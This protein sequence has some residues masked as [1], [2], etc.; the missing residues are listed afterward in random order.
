MPETVSWAACSQIGGRLRGAGP[1]REDD[2]PVARRRLHGRH[3]GDLVRVGEGHAL[4]EGRDVD[5]HLV[6]ALRRHRDHPGA[7]CAAGG[8]ALEALADDG[9]RHAADGGLG[10]LDPVLQPAADLLA[11][12]RGG[13]GQGEQCDECDEDG[14][15]G[16]H[17]ASL[18][19]RRSSREPS[20]PPGT[21]RESSADV[22]QRGQ[23]IHVLDTG[24]AVSGNHRVTSCYVP[25]TGRMRQVSRPVHSGP[26]LLI[27]DPYL[28]ARHG[29]PEGERL[30]H[31]G[32]GALA[33]APVVGAGDVEPD[34]HEALAGVQGRPDGAGR[35][36]QD[37]IG[38]AVQ[39]AVGLGV[40]RHRHREHDPLGGGLDELDAHRLAEGTHRDAVG[41]G[42]G[43]CH[44]RRI[45]SRRAG[46]ETA[47]A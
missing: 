19:A 11:L 7:V 47:P 18:H 27:G 2:D 1:E 17:D 43:W 15:E 24:V 26:A 35:L 32:D 28:V 42:L 12:G 40:A 29:A 22:R 30:G 41:R 4:R 44:A 3:D 6:V 31:G 20:L 33:G 5:R 39:Q 14:A 46:I 16:G 38:A 8:R 34:D 13:L 45:G 25:I 9:D 37:G 10:A 36:D 23:H 21:G